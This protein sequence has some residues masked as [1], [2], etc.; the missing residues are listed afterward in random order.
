MSHP[1]SRPSNAISRSASAM[2]V[3]HFRPAPMA[4]LVQLALSSSLLALAALTPL[5]AMAQHVSTQS[6]ETDNQRRYDIPAGPLDEALSRFAVESG[7]LLAVQAELVQDKRSPGL[8]GSYSHQAALNTLL[9]GTGLEAIGNGRQQYRI[10]ANA[11]AVSELAPVHVMGSKLNDFSTEGSLS[12]AADGASMMKGAESL[13]EVPQSVSIVTR[14]QIEDQNLVSLT[15]VLDK[16]TGVTVVRNGA[17]TSSYAN[18]SNFYSR[19]FAVNNIQL[20]GGAASANNLNGMGSISQMDMA[21]YDHVEFLRGIDGLFSSTGEP[22]GT[23]NLVR[24]RAQATPK[25]SM[26]AS[27]GR[28][29]NY[30]FEGD[31]TGALAL[32]GAIRGRMGLA[33]EDRHYF[34]DISKSRRQLWY[35]SLEADLG[36]NTL[37]TLGGSFQQD[38]GIPFSGGLPRFSNGEDINL[39]RHTA[40][41]ADW[42]KVEDL[43]RQLYAK[44]EHTLNDDWQLT[45]NLDRMQVERDAMSL[46]SSGAVDPISGDGA[47]WFAFPARTGSTRTTLNANVKGGFMLLD[48]RHELIAGVDIE[49]NTAYS[50]QANTGLNGSPVDVLNRVQPADPGRNAEYNWWDYNQKRKA[51]YGSLKLRFSDTLALI[52]GG[53]YSRY[54]YE[55]TGRFASTPNRNEIRFKESGIFTPYAALTYDLN[56]T[57]TAYASYGETYAPQY[58]QLAGPL[59]GTALDPITS[60]NYETGLKGALIPGKLNTSFSLYRI[61]RSGEAVVDPAYPQSWGAYSCCYL[62]RGKVI[63]QGFEA[64]ISGEVLPGLQ[65][66]AGYTFNDNKSKDSGSNQRYNSVTPK[67]LLKIWANYRLPGEAQRWQVGGGVQIQSAHYVDG[68]AATY[69]PV[70]GD[71]SGPGQPFRFSQASYAVWSARIDY[72]LTPDW[73]IALNIHNLFDKRY[74]QT[75]GTSARGN[76]YGEPRN[77]MLT[78]RGSF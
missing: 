46:F 7:V 52:L 20:D 26:A 32:N 8:A 65:L 23:V 49:K 77:A 14:Q 18:D 43:T 62:N 78:L 73:N 64:E 29:D 10:Q 22:G 54:D 2:S 70:N 76:F 68:T 36:A 28:W 39:P 71:W 13:R 60:K 3:P 35:G 53:R 25:V 30:R 9:A 72:K 57:W 61:E 66:V 48:Q 38:K 16:T 40:L 59:P 34:Y 19:G 4:L 63:S 42:N 44:L 5:Q 1:P 6:T 55:S 74:Y 24:K 33:L 69:D 58:S 41:T 21:Q 47:Y 12:Y 27:A 45:L 31:V 51:V 17:S 15:D 50:Y 75:V 56:D 11:R 37:L 67:H